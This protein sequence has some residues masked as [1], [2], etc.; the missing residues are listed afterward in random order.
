MTRAWRAGLVAAL[1]AF[2]ALY[3][4]P[5]VPQFRLCGWY[6]LTGWPCPLCGLTRAMCQ[7]FHA[8]LRSALEL[9]ALSP[10]VVVLLLALVWRPALP[11]WVWIGFGGAAFVYDIWRILLP[12]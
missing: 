4:A 5:L 7:L 10:L 6:W 1:F 9:N 3:R 8:Q 12:S 11:G 2:F